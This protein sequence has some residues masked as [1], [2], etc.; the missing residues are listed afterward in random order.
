MEKKKVT[1]GKPFID[2][3]QGLD[4][5]VQGLFQSIEDG[6]AFKSRRVELKSKTNVF[7]IKQEQ[8]IREKPLPPPIKKPTTKEELI[9]S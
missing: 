7:L 6:K 9:N 8:R 3:K 2:E 4:A 5:A 1:G